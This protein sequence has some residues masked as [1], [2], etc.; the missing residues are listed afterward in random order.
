MTKSQIILLSLLSL[1]GFHAEAQPARSPGQAPPSALRAYLQPDTVSTEEM[2]SSF[3]AYKA[4]Q[5]KSP[6][7]SEYDQWLDGAIV[8]TRMLSAQPLFSDEPAVADWTCRD[9]TFRLYNLREPGSQ[10]RDEALWSKAAGQFGT[11]ADTNSSGKVSQVIPAPWLS[12]TFVAIAEPRPYCGYLAGP[13]REVFTIQNGQYPTERVFDHCASRYYRAGQQSDGTIRVDGQW[14]ED[15]G[16]EWLLFSH[17]ASQAC[18]P[19]P[20]LT[21]NRWYDLLLTIDRGGR[22][23]LVM[24]APEQATDEKD[25]RYVEE[26]RRFVR[27]LEPW[28]VEHLYTS[29]DRVLP[30]RYIKACRGTDYWSI[31]DYLEKASDQAH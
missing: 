6:R 12:G 9:R 26:L 14:A 2:V 5:K 27:G 3:Q 1:A 13:V 7:R 31:H 19:D 18:T 10:Q 23:D 30:G 11:K 29:D 22:L 4:G 20:A 17:D 15:L 28:A 8:T 25:R 16:K 21:T 24:L